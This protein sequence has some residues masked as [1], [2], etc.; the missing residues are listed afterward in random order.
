VRVEVL[1]VASKKVAVV[2]RALVLLMEAA[3]ASVA[4][5]TTAI[6]R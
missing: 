2:M 5:R 6:F 1:T 4:T 3:S